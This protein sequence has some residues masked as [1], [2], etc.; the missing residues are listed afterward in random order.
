MLLPKPG[1][2][3]LTEADYPTAEAF[4]VAIREAKHGGS[5]V[6]IDDIPRARV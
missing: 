2:E 4:A 1:A 3:I 5:V 6:I